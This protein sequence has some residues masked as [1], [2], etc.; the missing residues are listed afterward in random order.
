MQPEGSLLCSQQPNTC[1]YPKRD[2][3][4]NPISWWPI[5]ILSSK[6]RLCLPYGLVL[7][8]LHT[9][10]CIHLSPLC[11]KCPTHYF[12]LG[13]ITRIFEI[14]FLAMTLSPASCQFL[15]PRPQVSLSTTF[16]NTLSLFSSL[17]AQ[18]QASW[19]HEVLKLIFLGVLTSI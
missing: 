15:L 18:H 16:S 12:L 3:Y 9:K 5:L 19:P 4:P 8:D 1:L 13:L 2:P 11:A 10:L 6:L 14:R 17:N 7:S